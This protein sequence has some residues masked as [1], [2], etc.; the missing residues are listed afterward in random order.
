LQGEFGGE[1]FAVVTIATGRN[2]V[3]AITRLFDEVGVTRLPILLDPKQQ[4]SRDMAVMGLPVT[5]ILNPEGQEI[6][7][8]SGDA[9]WSG[10]S[11]RAII[12]A[13]L[14]GS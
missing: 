2:M 3:P 8:M 13:L 9:E 10:D 1:T 6:A 12:A 5:V 7:R 11:G 14:A 4:L